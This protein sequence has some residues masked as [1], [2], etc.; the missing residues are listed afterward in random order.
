MDRQQTTG[1]ILLSAML[2]LYF[3]YF[4]EQPAQLPPAGGADTVQVGQQGEQAA[5]PE[6]PDS[7]LRERFGFFALGKKGEPQQLVLEN[8]DVA[9]TF[10][11]LGG[12]VQSVRLKHYVSHSKQ[13]LVLLDAQ[14]S[15]IEE[16]W[17][18][19]HGDIDLN[20]LHYRA[21]VSGNRIT[22]ELADSART[23]RRTYTLDPQGY[24]L[25]YAV[26]AQ[27]LEGELAQGPV[28]VLWE[29]R[30][31]RVEKDLPTSRLR[32]TVN[33]YT[34]E[35]SFDY[36]SETSTSP[37]SE[38]LEEPLRWVSMKQKFFNAALI[39]DKAFGQATVGLLPVAEAD[40]LTVKTAT[41][42]VQLPQADLLGGAAGVRY[43]FGPNDLDVCKTVAPGFDENVYLGWALFVPISRFFII[44]FF[45]FLEGY[46]AN[47]GII[48]LVLV[49]VVKMLLFP[50]TYKSYL[51]MA[52]M[53]VL[54]PEMDALKEQYGDD[55]QKI[56]QET[57][58]IQGQF[59]VSPLS[60]CI[61]MLAQMPILIAL[62]TFFP[63][64][65][66][67]RQQAFLW[68]DDLSSYDSIL[69]LP[70]SIPM[71]GAH[72]SLFTLLMTA[73]TL[74]NTYFNNQ[75][76]SS[77][78][79]MQGPMKYMG[80]IMP[81]MFLFFLNSYSAGLT[82]YYFLSTSITVVQQLVSKQ[83]IDEAQI[84]AK[85]EENRQKR[86]GKSS[87]LERMGQAMREQQQRDPGASDAPE[88]GKGAK[89]L[90][91]RRRKP[92]QS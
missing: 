58:R 25:R 50:L 40:T 75:M 26:E 71:Y 78:A 52:K 1:F 84:R 81:I 62:F 10:S 34:T 8:D 57:L 73:V 21:S 66:Q 63:N 22:F 49:F 92:G 27:G 6:I 85:L 5:K 11:S 79:A 65:I 67:L 89:N 30:M 3:V 56:Q 13:P 4:G 43:Y 87:F 76:N 64:A 69:D 23:L 77:S 9:I 39:T 38:T 61:P 19:A 86:K 7:V 72:V 16:L 36:L 59:G 29:N 48:I 47:Y 46:I 28:K 82:Y 41:A 68:A 70:F 31:K 83:F 90:K 80:Y 88:L 45:E 60:G 74:V 53:R 33:Y 37:Q 24:V 17:P 14:S 2:M 12:A 20:S 42:A 51:S 44:P 55:M 15:R 35:G 32:A 18:T 91:G 54:K